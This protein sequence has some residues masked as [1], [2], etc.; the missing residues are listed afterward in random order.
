MQLRG[1]VHAA[2]EQ[3]HDAAAKPLPG[4]VAAGNAGLTAILI[5]DRS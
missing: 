2:L 1:L 3:L 4:R 5:A